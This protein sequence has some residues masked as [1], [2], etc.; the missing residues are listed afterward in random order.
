MARG[1]RGPV[2]EALADRIEIVAGG[3]LL[4]TIESKKLETILND[5]QPA[6]FREPGIVKRRLQVQLSEEVLSEHRN[7]LANLAQEYLRIKDAK[8]QADADFNAQI[9]TLDGEM[10]GVV[11]GLKGLPFDVDC[12]WRVID[13]NARGL[14]RLDTGECIEMAALTAEDRAEE[15]DEANDMNEVPF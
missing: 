7:A 14:F 1:K 6:L 12:Q 3:G 5:V 10:R 15:L 11:K 8:K 2:P 4:G 9:N 13:G